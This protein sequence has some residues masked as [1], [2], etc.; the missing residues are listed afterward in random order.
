MPSKLAWSL[1]Y[2]GY[3]LSKLRNILL[4]FFDGMSYAVAVDSSSAA[5]MA[6]K[7]EKRPEA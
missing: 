5:A 6:C 4:I 1:F 3:I 2:S 7:L